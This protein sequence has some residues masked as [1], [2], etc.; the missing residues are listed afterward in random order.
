MKKFF[1]IRSRSRKKED[2]SL[3]APPELPNP[4]PPPPPVLRGKV[5]TPRPL[6]SSQSW[7]YAVK[8]YRNTVAPSDSNDDGGGMGVLRGSSTGSLGQ[9]HHGTV[10]DVAGGYEA[11][12]SG[13]DNGRTGVVAEGA[14]TYEPPTTGEGV[15]LPLAEHGPRRKTPEVEG[16][17]D[18]AKDGSATETGPSQPTTTTAEEIAE[19]L[20]QSDA[21]LLHLDNLRQPQGT[22]GG[23]SGPNGLATTSVPTLPPGSVVPN[24]ADLLDVEA[25][26]SPSSRDPFHGI[27]TSATS[28]EANPT[29]NYRQPHSSS[30]EGSSHSDTYHR[31]PVSYREPEMPDATYEEYY[32][33]AYVGAPIKYVYPSGYQSM[34]PRG[35]PW[36]LSILICVL[37]T[38]LSV[39]IV[40]HCSDRGEDM[41]NQYNNGED[42]DDDVV[43]IETR[44][45][46]SKL[47]YFM[48]V[49]SMLITGLSM[50]YCGIIGYIK[51][52]DFAVA[53]CRSQPPG[54]V[55][56][57]DY[58]VRIE[59]ANKLAQSGGS[60]SQPYKKSI[61]QSDG[62][63][64]FWGGHIYRPTQAAVAVT[65]R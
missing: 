31:S 2:S 63:P 24:G 10:Y 1:G 23:G 52:R 45:C 29:I 44:W 32:G 12:G 18:D 62:T 13:A 11:G 51:V 21:D 14:G 47:L 35:G 27:A 50:A 48:W 30:G 41:G 5:P 20:E 39:F 43:V 19:A 64:Q 3:T 57:S 54:M 22:A 58:Y 17:A 15:A 16:G 8:E 6:P 56:K 36:K 33:D 26:S 40:G 38:W 42:I 37:F 46:G 34:R 61:Y 65:S 55:G 4:P 25:P 53:N 60:S 7:Q 49:I 59:E 28:G 9:R